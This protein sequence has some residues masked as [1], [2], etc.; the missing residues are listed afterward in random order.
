MNELQFHREEN[1]RLKRLVFLTTGTNKKFVEKQLVNNQRKIRK[2]ISEHK[3]KI[4]KDIVSIY[5]RVREGEDRDLN[6]KI[7]STF[8]RQLE[9]EE[10]ISNIEY[11][12][13][14]SDLENI[15]TSSKTRQKYEIE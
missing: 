14:V 12:T 1:T 4:R 2:I 9:R 10:V 5:W 13:Y 6:V 3:S 15:F 8:L 11:H 7:F